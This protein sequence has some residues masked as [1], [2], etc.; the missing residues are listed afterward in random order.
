MTVY[1]SFNVK[2]IDGREVEYIFLLR[3]SSNIE[4]LKDLA[5]YYKGGSRLA[6][7]AEESIKYLYCDIDKRIDV[8]EED[9][10]NIKF[11]IDTHTPEAK[12]EKSFSC[13]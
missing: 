11:Y 1:K 9:K 5:S 12:P 4:R 3:Y 8:N 7:K 13:Y 6:K 2:K 10:K